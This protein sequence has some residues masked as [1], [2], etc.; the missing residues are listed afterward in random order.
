MLS[1]HENVLL[2]NV[3]TN[4]LGKIETIDV[5]FVVSLFFRL[6]IYHNT[7]THTLLF[8]LNVNILLSANFNLET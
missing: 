5:N 3:R 4:I 6:N 1:S 7:H 2:K 8:N